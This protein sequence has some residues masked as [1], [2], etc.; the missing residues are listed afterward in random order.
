VPLAT[1]GDLEPYIAR[2]ADSDASPVP[3]AKPVTSISL[4]LA[5]VEYVL[6]A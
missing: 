3:T 4:R 1:H 6:A 2:I 5:M